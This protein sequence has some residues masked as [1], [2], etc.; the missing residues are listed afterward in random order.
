MWVAVYRMAWKFSSLIHLFHRDSQVK[1]LLSL[2]TWTSPLVK[3]SKCSIFHD[4]LRTFSIFVFVLSRNGHFHNNVVKLE[5]ENGIVSTLSNVVHVNVGNTQCWFDVVLSCKFHCWNT[6]RFFNV[7]P[8]SRRRINQKT[9]LKQRWN[10]CWA[11]S[12]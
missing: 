5:V 1:T 6:Q 10:V 4:P 2:W 12:F 3:F 7:G 9:T 11:N 8:T